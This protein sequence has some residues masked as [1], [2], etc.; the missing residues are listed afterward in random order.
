[1]WYLHT[2]VVTKIPAQSSVFFCMII[3]VNTVCYSHVLIVAEQISSRITK[4]MKIVNVNDLSQKEIPSPKSTI[5]IPLLIS[6][7]HYKVFNQE[8]NRLKERLYLTV[9]RKLA[10]MYT[11]NS[12]N[13]SPSARYVSH[14]RVTRWKG[15]CRSKDADWNPS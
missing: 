9:N 14:K 8:L 10:N 5:T 12:G 2:R 13:A 1:M 15:I 4:W 6:C 7:S 11:K 3:Q